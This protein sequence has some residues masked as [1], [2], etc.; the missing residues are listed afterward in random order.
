K[1][2]HPVMK[3]QIMIFVF[4]LVATI[5]YTQGNRDVNYDESKVPEFDLPD[6]LISFDGKKI[7]KVR[8]WERIRRPELLEFFTTN[9]YGAVPG[10]LKFT[11]S[12]IVEESD[13]ALG[14][15]AI[16][17]QVDVV[18]ENNERKLSFN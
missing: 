10:E 14:G 7:K 11:E 2:N 4:L 18:F 1:F 13:D 3:K 17:R 15:K 9:V 16:R 5:A 8:Q 6:P 12:N